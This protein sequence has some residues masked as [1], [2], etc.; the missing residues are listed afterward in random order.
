MRAA[1]QQL[2]FEANCGSMHAV[3]CYHAEL[4][5]CSHW[6]ASKHCSGRLGKALAE[7][8]GIKHQTGTGND[9]PTVGIGRELYRPYRAVQA[10]CW[11][12]SKNKGGEERISH[13]MSSTQEQRHRGSSWTWA[14]VGLLAAGRRLH[15][16]T[17]DASVA[18]AHSQ[19]RG[20]AKETQIDQMP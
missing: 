2:M 19:V 4:T 6:I 1:D 12:W 20:K 5:V 9:R 11:R 18:W 16:Y 15:W 17:I 3:P 14:L 7:A 10:R 8:L 13:V